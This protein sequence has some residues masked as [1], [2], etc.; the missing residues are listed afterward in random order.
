M[1]GPVVGVVVAHADL[2]RALVEAV[3]RISGVEGVLH[4]LS[5]DSCTP[6]E[7]QRRVRECSGDGP[8]VVFV[9]LASGSCAFA[10]RRV[11][12]SCSGVAVVSGVNLPMLLDF[13]FHRD[14]ELPALVSRVVE[15][16]RAGAEMDVAAESG[17]VSA[18]DGVAAGDGS[19][20]EPGT[21][22]PRD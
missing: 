5:N 4:P 13:V 21:G 3:E 8:A 22:S 19:G 6:E 18:E 17:G 15:K 1:S 12:R 14:M 10:A 11:G 7:L 20:G 16:G 2:A 9:D